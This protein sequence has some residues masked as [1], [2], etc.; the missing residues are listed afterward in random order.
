MPSSTAYCQNGSSLW[1][2]Y[3]LQMCMQLWKLAKK[4]LQCVLLKTKIFLQISDSWCFNLENKI[5]LYSG[6]SHIM[7]LFF[8]RNWL[9]CRLITDFKQCKIVV[10][11]L[12]AFWLEKVKPACCDH[13][14]S[15]DRLELIYRVFLG[16]MNNVQSI[17]FVELFWFG[18]CTYYCILGMEQ[19]LN[20]IFPKFIF[21]PLHF[22]TEFLICYRCYWVK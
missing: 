1:I 5:L 14:Q 9:T 8:Y 19:H 15:Y 13:F 17:E 10:S 11:I 12:M 22:P 7:E 3:L 18:W 6:K 4:R 20:Q 16:N 2:L 21:H